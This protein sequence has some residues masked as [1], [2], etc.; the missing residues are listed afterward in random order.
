MK[1]A[2]PVILTPAKEGGYTVLVPDLQI[3]TQG[4]TIAECIDMARDAIGLWGICEQDANRSIPAPSKLPPPHSADEFVTF[5]DIDFNA[6]RRANDM[7]TVRKNVT[8]PS[9]LNDMAEKAGINFSQA[10]QESLKNRLN[11]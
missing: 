2:Y 3:N 11:I 7:R 1:E 5:V 4:E 8:I 6:Y 10:L 9:Y